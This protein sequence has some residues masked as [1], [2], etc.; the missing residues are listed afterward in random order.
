MNGRPALRATLAMTAPRSPLHVCA[1][2]I[3]IA[4]WHP[5]DPHRQLQIAL[6]AARPA[7]ATND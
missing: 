1:G 4:A 2:I 3:A 7:A 5:T 6:V